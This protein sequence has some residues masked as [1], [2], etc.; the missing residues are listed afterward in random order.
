MHRGNFIFILRNLRMARRNVKVKVEGVEDI[1]KALRKA[2]EE[3]KNE[4]HNIISEAA[5]IVFREADARVPIGKTEKARESLRIETGT[6]KGGFFYANV[7]VGG[8]EAFYI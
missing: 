3:L 2:D 1:L 6:D 5:E 4:L 8:K 7:V